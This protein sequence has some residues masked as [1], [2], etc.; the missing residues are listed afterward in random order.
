MSIDVDRLLEARNLIADPEH[1]TQETS[2]RDEYDREVHKDENPS[3]FCALGALAITYMPWSSRAEYDLLS[4]VSLDLYKQRVSIVNDEIGHEAILAIYD[5]A[6]R[7][8]KDG[9]C[10]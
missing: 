3:K 1:W 4:E 5:E 6:I 9:Y 2:F 8:A 10:G 7:R